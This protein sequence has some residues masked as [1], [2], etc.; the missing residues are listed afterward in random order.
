MIKK[1]IALSAFSLLGACST[2]S[3]S[4]IGNYDCNASKPVEMNESAI[5]EYRELRS[6]SMMKSALINIIGTD[7]CKDEVCTRYHPARYDFVERTYDDSKRKGVYTIK[8]TKNLQ[9]PNCFGVPEEIDGVKYCYSI[10]KNEN[11]EIKSR[12]KFTMVN[13][14]DYR[15]MKIDDLKNKVQVVKFSECNIPEGQRKAG[16]DFL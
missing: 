2:Y 14:D 15:V 5:K 9:D 10:T 4:T 1:I 13:K 7:V 12:Y 6:Q 16:I 11:D 3:N 8:A